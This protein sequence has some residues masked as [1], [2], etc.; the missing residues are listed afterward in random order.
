MAGARVLVADGDRAV[1][2]MLQIRLEVAGYYPLAAR[3]GP[4]VLDIMRNMRPAAL[5]LDLA[6]PE[7]DPFELLK[8]LH[9]D[10]SRPPSP[11]LLIGK[12]L[13]IEEIKR[14]ATLGV[15]T[16]MVKPFSGADLL[17]RVAKIL[18]AAHHPAAMSPAPVSG[19]VFV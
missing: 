13:G 16:C 14:A 4:G 1:S 3:N 9:N 18:K 12:R 8:I 17:E 15:R 7:M 11:I 10:R 19:E 5:V 6:I 2:E